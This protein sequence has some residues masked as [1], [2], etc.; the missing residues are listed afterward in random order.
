LKNDHFGPSG[1]VR[2]HKTKC[3][4]LT[5]FFL[6][7]SLPVLLFS[8]GRQFFRFFWKK[9]KSPYNCQERK[10]PPP[11]KIGVKI[12]QQVNNFRGVNNFCGATFFGGQTFWGQHFS[13]VKLL[14]GQKMLGLTFLG[15]YHFKSVK[16]FGGQ[17]FSVV[18]IFRGGLSK[19]Y[20]G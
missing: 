3:P 4:L 16:N 12:C 2:C 1:G 5:A 9:T 6:F 8:Q 20:E 14:G 10:L 18:T 7:V 13:G 17:Q 15:G 11:K 19:F